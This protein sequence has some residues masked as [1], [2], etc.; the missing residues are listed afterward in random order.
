V[1]VI[2]KP[3]EQDSMALRSE[4]GA[5]SQGIWVSPGTGKD[6]EAHSLLV[7]PKGTQ[8]CTTLIWTS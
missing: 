1:V 8:P 5:M 6:R 3:Y 2:G 7:P 4:D